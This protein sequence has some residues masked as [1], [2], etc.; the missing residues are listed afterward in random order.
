MVKRGKVRPVPVDQGPPERARHGN[1]V[2]RP[3]YNHAGAVI[4]S[5]R[6]TVTPIERVQG[7]DDGQLEAARR[8]RWDFEISVLRV[9]DLDS[10]ATE[11]VQSGRGRAEPTDVMID[12]GRRLAGARAALTYLELPIVEAVICHDH[13]IAT[14]AELRRINQ[15]EAT[16]ILKAG[17]ARLAVHYGAHRRAA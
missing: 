15:S 4:G 6:R 12:A 10:R 1:V 14:V 13:T 16:G 9:V 2:E 7:L 3:V 11:R 17:L 5:G 8:L